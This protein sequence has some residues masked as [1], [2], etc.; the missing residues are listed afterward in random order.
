MFGGCYSVD[1]AGERCCQ[2][3]QP[4]RS[5]PH[6]ESWLVSILCCSL[7]LKTQLNPFI[8]CC[9]FV[10]NPSRYE[11]VFFLFPATTFTVDM[12]HISY[13]ILFWT[14]LLISFSDQGP[15]VVGTDVVGPNNSSQLPKAKH[16][17]VPRPRRANDY[18]EGVVITN[19]KAD[20]S[21]L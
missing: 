9:S 8:A 1:Q 3:A 16:E 2:L 7:Q 12:Q 10:N 20:T 6:Q 11:R 14:S 5:I 17:T 4:L 21:D 19:E 15:T 18:E 13:H